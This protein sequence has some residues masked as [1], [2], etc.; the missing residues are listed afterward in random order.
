MAIFSR[1]K[2]VP[3]SSAESTTPAACGPQPKA[4]FGVT[5]SFPTLAIT[6]KPDVNPME[7]RSSPVADPLRSGLYLGSIRIR[8]EESGKAA[9]VITAARRN[10]PKSGSCVL[11][12]EQER[13]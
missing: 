10:N 2:N 1:P 6:A 12:L 4:I 13:Q 9:L 7:T 11:H 3:F 5:S 8:G